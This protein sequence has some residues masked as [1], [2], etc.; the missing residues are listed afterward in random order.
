MILFIAVAAVFAWQGERFLA[1]TNDSECEKPQVVVVLAGSTHEDPG[2]VKEGAAVFREKGA[3]YLMFPLRHPRINWSW[4]VKKYRIKTK[5]PKEKVLI[6]RASVKDQKITQELGGT[7]TEA[8]MTIRIMEERNIKSALV[9]TSGYHVRRAGLA[10]ER[11]LKG[12]VLTFCFHGVERPAG[13][14]PWWL[15][16]DYLF[17][18]LGEY[19]KLIGSYFLYR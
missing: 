4:L 9:V 17:R 1:G 10:F 11:A 6:G 2:R 15:D 8:E 14:G 5:V 3:D 12:R 16:R 19:K 13:I 7:F 18:V